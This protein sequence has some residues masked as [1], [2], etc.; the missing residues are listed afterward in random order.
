[1]HQ[2][3]EKIRYHLY[4]IDYRLGTTQSP[5]DYV[6]HG[7]VANWDLIPMFEMTIERAVLEADKD[8]REA[9]IRFI[10]NN[11]MKGLTLKLL[12]SFL[13]NNMIDIHGRE[14]W[15]VIKEN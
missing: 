10:R 13:T 2:L 4:K 11:D 9:L 6:P 7:F 12:L 5:D 15:E 8:N 14:L 1:M 3:D